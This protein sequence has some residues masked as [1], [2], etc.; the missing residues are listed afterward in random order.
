MSKS[1]LHHTCEWKSIWCQGHLKT[2]RS[3]DATKAGDQALTSYLVHGSI[4]TSS[5]LSLP[6]WALLTFQPVLQFTLVIHLI[7]L[8]S[9]TWSRVDIPSHRALLSSLSAGIRLG[10]ML[11]CVFTH[12]PNDLLPPFCLAQDYKY[13]GY[14]QCEKYANVGL[15]MWSWVSAWP[16]P[17]GPGFSSSS[18]HRTNSS[19]LLRSFTLETKF[20]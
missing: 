7:M 4:W 3:Q 5:Q 1:H 13:W 8:C 15:R 12:S 10:W 6:Q 14:N 9:Q 19:K 20:N 18:A 16:H 17:R 11:L 2:P